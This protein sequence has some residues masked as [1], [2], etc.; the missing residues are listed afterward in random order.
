MIK[1]RVIGLEDGNHAFDIH[2]E[3]LRMSGN[4]YEFKNISIVGEL[5]IH[6]TKVNLKG[7][8]EASVDLNCDRSGKDFTE[9]IKKEV[10][11]IFK[12]N[13]KGI[14]ILDD[15]IDNSLFRLEGNLLNIN[16]LIY[17]ELL[18]TIPLKK[19]APEYRDVEFENLF[20]D[21]ID[22]NTGKDEKKDTSTWNELKK[23]NFN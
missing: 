23:L 18:L 10:D 8:L 1:I 21:F 5:I 14:E 12:F 19:I 11:F 6:G 17:E 4:D 15:D 13:A 3:K 16:D 2:T 20:P 7:N 22:K 9:N